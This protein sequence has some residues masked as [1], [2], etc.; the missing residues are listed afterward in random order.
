MKHE[1]TKL[2]MNIYV[3]NDRAITHAEYSY[4][5]FWH[6]DGRSIDF[7]ASPS[8]NKFAQAVKLVKKYYPN[9]TVL[10]ATKAVWDAWH[11]K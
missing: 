3:S 5:R 4:W 2:P 11:R 10:P 6:E 7:G 1:E 8:V 9:A